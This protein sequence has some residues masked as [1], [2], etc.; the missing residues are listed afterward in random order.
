M[1]RTTATIFVATLAV[2]LIGSTFAL[3]QDIMAQGGIGQNTIKSEPPTFDT[4][5]I[6]RMTEIVR[7]LHDEA[8]TESERAELI[9]E[10]QQIK[11]S[12]EQRF[13]STARQAMLDKKDVIVEYISGNLNLRSFDDFTSEFPVSGLYVDSATNKLVVNVFPDEFDSNAESVLQKVRE[14]VGRD[15]DITVQP[16]PAITPQCSQTGNCEPAQG[17]VKISTAEGACSMGFKAIRNGDIGFVTAGHCT[18]GSTDATVGQPNYYYWDHIGSVTANSY[19]FGS[20]ADA[21]FVEADESI[22]DRIYNNIDINWAG[23]TGLLDGVHMEGHTSKGV[24]G[25]V[26]DV[27]YSSYVDSVWINDM[28]ATTYDGDGGDSG[29]PVY[30]YIPSTNFKGTHVGSNGIISTYSKQANILDEI[31]GLSWRFT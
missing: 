30:G 29:G 2:G 16:M 5:D 13:D 17:G 11:R 20:S 31:S 8:T 27:S 22:S 23:S 28:A 19:R 6:Q 26:V 15:I 4:P 10:A 12:H 18:D 7:Q 25:V 24:L 14:L 9:E 1:N 21:M 3:S